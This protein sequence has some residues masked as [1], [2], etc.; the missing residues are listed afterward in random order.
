MQNGNNEVSYEK[1][2][3]HT[4]FRVSNYR[5]IIYNLIYPS[6]HSSTAEKKTTYS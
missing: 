4:T 5:E 1:Q 6:K 3:I 2:L